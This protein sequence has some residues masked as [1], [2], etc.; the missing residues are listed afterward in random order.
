MRRL[1]EG[2]GGRREVKR[3]GEGCGRRRDRSGAS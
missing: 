3:D 1:G 2:C